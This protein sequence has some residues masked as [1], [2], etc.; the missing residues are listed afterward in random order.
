[1]VDQ[2][3]DASDENTRPLT[4]QERQVLQRHQQIRDNHLAEAQKQQNILIELVTLIGGEG[5]EVDLGE[6]TISLPADED[7]GDEGNE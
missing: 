4:Q 7:K 3:I 1:M 2:V 5:A 6:G